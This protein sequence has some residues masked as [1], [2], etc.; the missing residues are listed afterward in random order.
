MSE[1]PPQ[2]PEAPGA[3]TEA[4]PGDAGGAGGRTARLNAFA[5]R[6]ETLVPLDRPAPFG[7]WAAAVVAL[8]AFIDRVEVNLVAGALPA[9]QDHFGFSDTWAGAIPTAAA[10]AGV[11]LLLPAG[12]LA[13]TGRRT[14]II[15]LVVL[16]W[17][18]CSV[19]SGLATTFAL[20]FVTRIMLGAAGQ[21]Y[22]PPASS[23][24][25]DYYPGQAR[26]KAYGLERAGYYLGL[27]V[28]VALGGAVADALGWRAVFFVIAVPGVLVALLV[29]TLRE[30]IRG[31]GDRIDRLRARTNADP[32]APESEV[33]RSVRAGV[34]AE[35]R[36]LLRI[37]TL[38]GVII[39]LALLYL[40]LGGLFYWLPTLLE[41]TE[42]LAYDTA[43]GLAGAVGGT[44]IVI[45]ILLGSRIG[46]RF[47]GVRDG[48]RIRVSLVFL[49]LGAISITAVVL[50]PG[51]GLRIALVALACVGF[52]GAIPNLTAASADVVPA[53]QRGIGF[54]LVQ[55]LLTL[56]GA[57]GPLLIGAVSDATGSI[58]T[59][60]LA[61]VP[62]LFASVLVLRFAATSYDSDAE[63]ALAGR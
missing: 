33:E 26:G 24:L 28:G 31:I 55:F 48:W 39:S 7:W 47:H 8:V 59:A 52:A 45:G 49:L 11:V 44:G 57:V 1:H 42:S 9:I 35:A 43:A 41:R 6:G 58:N 34:V 12:R 17:A 14:G 60:F 46:D 56:G 23:L 18:V 32:S 63:R 40:G 4:T 38:R 10:V 36:A 21:L 61:L 16:A 15:A 3:A 51:L 53:D 22:N 27:P 30:P 50:L 29:L 19:L 37:R 62:P 2:D 20:F 13:D 25:A 54:A 5:G